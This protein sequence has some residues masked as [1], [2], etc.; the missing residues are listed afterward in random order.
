MFETKP[1]YALVREELSARILSGKYA[2]GDPL[3]NEWVLSTELG[4]SI[5]T[6][7]KAVQS[8]VDCRL[9]LRVSGR[10]TVVADRQS[11]AYKAAF[12][13]FRDE[14]GNPVHWSYEVHSIETGAANQAEAEKLHVDVGD[15]VTR[16]VRTRSAHGNKVMYEDISIPAERIRIDATTPADQTTIQALSEVNGRAIG[17][18]VKTLFVGPPSE[19]ARDMLPSD[20]AQYFINYE[21]LVYDSKDAP[22]EWCKGSVNC[23]RLSYVADIWPSSKAPAV[24]KPPML[25]AAR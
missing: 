21:R 2:P 10:G 15:E 7:R 14:N 6:L 17:L 19:A 13:R 11:R 23:R 12:D 1:L 4:V 22:I 20:D 3:P 5:G 16:I 25:V 24:V 8:L 9:L 18:I